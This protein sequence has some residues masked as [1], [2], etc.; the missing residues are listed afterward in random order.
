MMRRPGCW[1]TKP[2]PHPWEPRILDTACGYD[3]RMRHAGCAGCHR[4][5]EESPL[6][7][8]RAMDARHT[9]DGRT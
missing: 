6:D 2:L 5:R 4:Q 8:L 1:R 9:E 7:Q 3:E